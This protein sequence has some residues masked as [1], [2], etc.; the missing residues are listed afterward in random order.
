[1]NFYFFDFNYFHH[2]FFVYLY[3]LKKTNAVFSTWK[4]QRVLEKVAS[5]LWSVLFTPIFF[6]YIDSCLLLEN[7]CC[8]DCCFSQQVRSQTF[9][10]WNI[11][12]DYSSVRIAFNMINKCNTV[13]LVHNVL[14]KICLSSNYY[15]FTMN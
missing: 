8:W 9:V 15:Y 1:M 4:S 11:L 2:F 3:L 5:R 13:P 7:S 12:Q 6:L 10:Q 14:V